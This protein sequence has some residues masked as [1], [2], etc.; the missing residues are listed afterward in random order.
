MSGSAAR[1]S[2][3]SAVLAPSPSI[4]E[5]NSA[6]LPSHAGPICAVTGATGF[7]GRSLVALLINK[8]FRVRGTVRNLQ[9]EAARIKELHAQFPALEC[10]EADLLSAESFI[11]PFHDAE[12][13]FHTAFPANQPSDDPQTELVDPALHGTVNVIKAAL[14]FDT[15][16]KIVLTSSAA[17]ARTADTSRPVTEKDWNDAATLESNPFAHS[18]VLTERMAQETIDAHNLE[19]PDNSV[20]LITILPS[21]V[22]GPPVSALTE[23]VGLKLIKS[24]FNTAEDGGIDRLSV[25]VVDVRDVAKAHLAAIER[26]MVHGRYI[27]S[28]PDVLSSLDLVQALQRLYP[29]RRLASKYGEGGAEVAA[30]GP[31]DNSRAVRELGVKL[32]PLD[33]VLQ[34]TVDRM[35][36][37]GMIKE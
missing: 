33:Q 13:I 29:G 17:A 22:I 37:L 19:N 25:N 10:Y 27:V 7:L 12:Y 5:L 21:W 20:T 35:M 4:D 6:S 34:D 31:L 32:T 23:S 11:K 1:T 3:R 14:Q 28:L 18:K 2:P 16:K 26:P 30:V 36:E 9:E 15:V 8:G 24:W